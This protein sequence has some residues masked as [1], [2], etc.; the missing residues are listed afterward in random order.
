MR[1]APAE[2]RGVACD[3]CSPRRGARSGHACVFAPAARLRLHASAPPVGRSCIYSMRGALAGRSCI[4][5][6]PSAPPAG[7]DILLHA[8]APPLPVMHLLHASAPPAGHAS[9]PSASAGHA[10]GRSCRRFTFLSTTRDAPDKVTLSTAQAERYPFFATQ[11]HPEKNMYEFNSVQVPHSLSAKQLAQASPTS[12]RRCANQFCAVREPVCHCA[13][14]RR[15][16]CWHASARCDVACIR[17][18][19]AP[20]PTLLAGMHPALCVSV[21][22]VCMHPRIV[23]FCACAGRPALAGLWRSTRSH[24]PAPPRAAHAE[25]APLEAAAA[26]AHSAASTGVHRRAQATRPPRP[27]A[28][29]CGGTRV[30]APVRPL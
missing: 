26:S 11:W 4:Y 24:P 25:L 30:P 2:G 19:C 23:R 1:S 29:A 8:S 3:A 7:H 18:L 14:P 27:R 13:R 17:A 20:S 12:C 15:R 22:L 28:R 9:P 21:L 5:S 16:C 10:G 6:M